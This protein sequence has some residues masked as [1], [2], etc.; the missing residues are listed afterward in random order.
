[1]AR[2]ESYR[3]AAVGTIHQN[4]PT[5]PLRAKCDKEKPLHTQKQQPKCSQKSATMRL[6]NVPGDRVIITL[7]L[8]ATTAVTAK[9]PARNPSQRAELEKAKKQNPQ[10]YPRNLPKL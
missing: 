9:Q 4:T 3:K 5:E 8:G 2:N 7:P 10:K 6:K 1:M